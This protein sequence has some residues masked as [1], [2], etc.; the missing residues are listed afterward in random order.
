LAIAIVAWTASAL[1]IAAV[2]YLVLT[3]IGPSR[4]SLRVASYLVL[5][6]SVTTCLQLLTGLLG[7]LKPVPIGVASAIGLLIVWAWPATRRVLR[8]AGS[9][10]RGL[11]VAG[12]AAWASFPGWLRV[13]SCVLVPLLVLRF[14]F[15]IWA[16]PP[17][18][19]DSLTYHLPNVAAWTQAGR[20]F[21]V[22]SPVNRML[23]P[24]NFEVFA[25]WFTVFLH[26]DIVVEAA[27]LPAYALGVVSVYALGRVIGLA[28]WSSW[29]AT[30]GFATTPALL[31]AATGTKNDPIMAG[32]F[33]FILAM[34]WEM[35][36]STGD[37]RSHP[38]WGGGVLILLAA[39]LGLGTKAYILQML[40][41]ALAIV[42]LARREAG[43]PLS[44]RLARK[45]AGQQWQALS[46]GGRTL[47]LVV[48]AV[49]LVLGTYWY[50]RN[51]ILTGN[52][53]Y[54]YG[55]QVGGTMVVPAP[56]DAARMTWRD[57]T[58]NLG[59]LAERFGD[60]RRRI[61]PDL[62]ETTGWGWVAYGLGMPA[63]AWGLVRSKRQRILFV[64]FALALLLVIQASPTSLWMT[65]FLTWVPALLCLTVGEA[66]EGLGPGSRLVRWAFAGLFTAAC[67]LNVSMT[68]NY[69][70]V[71]PDDFKAML[72]KPALQRQA[73][74]L[75]VTVPPEYAM[76]LALVPPDTVLGYNV[77]GNGFTYPLYRADYSQHL[78]YIPIPPGS[79]CVEIADAMRARGTRYLFVA[80]EHT[81]DWILS[82]L[83]ACANEQDVLRERVRGLYVDKRG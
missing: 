13:L 16:L 9:E 25:T 73:S 80:P 81:E 32:L 20:I 31:L 57:F 2:S 50:A 37:A 70:I 71:S 44:L 24:A 52:P 75:Q 77:H 54:P 41:G 66:M 42:L 29:L 65:R 30:L 28:P 23:S 8:G 35:A 46:A 63:L 33:L 58:T 12:S 4:V 51:W 47:S 36:S 1:W 19:W 10:A 59:S 26:H 49:A 83:N 40:I 18:V 72:N 68:L 15:L 79:T 53:L 61:S 69:N 60:K 64:G 34:G 14:A 21:A 6:I 78:A 27:G 17:F 48:V 3:A 76:A 38:G 11:W 5:L 55:V 62:P 39:G 43:A 56:D 45:S 67:A 7:L 82:L 22:E 74:E